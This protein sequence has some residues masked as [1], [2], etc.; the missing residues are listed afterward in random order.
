MTTPLRFAIGIITYRR[1]DM[2]LRLI[3]ELATSATTR[4]SVVVVDNNPV[5]QLRASCEH[6]TESSLVDVDVLWDGENHG[7]AAGR[8]LI[9]DKADTDIVVFLDDDARVLDLAAML[10]LTASAMADVTVAACAFNI[11]S[12]HGE[13]R[14]HEIPHADKSVDMTK[15]FETYLLVGAGHAVRRDTT[16]ELGAYPAEFGLY[17]VEETD[18]AFR[19]IN[20][21]F[22]ICYLAGVNVVH[23]RTPGGRMDRKHEAWLLYVNRCKL[24]VKWFSAP[25]VASNVMI[26]SGHY[27]RETRDLAGLWRGSRAILQSREL[28]TA[29]F[30]ATFYKRVKAMNGRIV[31]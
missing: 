19:M 12:Q 26:W 13:H 20:A 31:Y 14:R 29:P 3:G 10:S 18:L 5:D 27:L 24:A 23:E 22:R 21:G 1:D 15:D 4:L 6:L 9:L 28:R 25:Y 8:N 2:F 16:R 11:V 7:V 30:N 17:G